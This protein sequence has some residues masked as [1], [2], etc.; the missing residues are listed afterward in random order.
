MIRDAMLAARALR[1]KPF[2]ALVGILTLAF[3]LGATTAVFAVLQAVLLRPLPYADPDRLVVLLHDGQSPVSPADYLDYR[4]QTRSFS[5]MAAAQV[6]TVTLT[7][8]GDPVRT[9]AL[10]V[11]S[12][13]FDTLGVPAALGRTFSRDDGAPGRDRV[14]VLSDR[15]WRGRFRADPHAIGRSITLDGDPYTVI[16]VMPPSFQFAPFWAT[17]AQLWR[18]LDLS[19]RLTDRGGRSLRVFARLR[20]GTSLQNAQADASAVAARLSAAYPD[21]NAKLGISVVPLQ[22]RV[23]ANTR[24]TLQSIAVMVAL[25]LLIACV[26][27][28]TLLLVW[29]ASR[30]RELAVRA[31]LGASRLRLIRER[32]AEAAILSVAGGLIGVACA[33]IAVNLLVASLPPASLPRQQDIG[34]DPLV[35]AAAAA[36]SIVCAA[37]AGVVP[38][39]QLSRRAGRD[40]LREGGRTM[41]DHAGGARL[42]R[43]LLAVEVALA[44]ALLCGA[45]LVGRSLLALQAV[46]PGFDPRGVLTFTL[47][48]KGLPQGEPSARAPYFDAVAR[49]LSEVP[50]VR[51]VGAINHLPLAGDQ[52]RLT[53][54]IA[55]RAAPPP[56][57]RQGA[58]WRVVR[59]GYF[60]TMRLPVRGRTFTDGDRQNGLPVIIVNDAMARRHWPGRDPLGAQVRIGTEDDSQ[61]M[62]VVGVAADARQQDWTGAILEE[63]YVPYAQHA[64][65][66]GGAELSFVVRTAGD[67][68]SYV[69]RVQQAVWSVDPNVPVSGVQTMER[70]VSDQLWRARVTAALLGTF[71]IVALSL[72]AV[73]ILS[74]TSYVMSRRTREIGIRIALGASR[75]DVMRLAA[76]DTMLPIAG[77]VAAGAAASA[78]LSGLVR[79]L[80]YDVSP[81]DP[82]T[83]VS[84]TA[85]LLVVGMLAA[86]LPARR[87]SRI[88]PVRALREE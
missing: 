30:D 35:L 56:D 25:V 3:G 80:L 38:A 62:T 60:E 22:E 42:R 64:R 67:P 65:D 13:L 63:V 5:S 73:G 57:E 27:V 20:G 16:G 74:V 47:G 75:R 21:T 33:S 84:A 24:P 40:A 46:N 37:L 49:S 50:G 15:L 88:E 52:W 43:T 72:A 45:G 9:E 29:G 44:L 68:D 7:G 6:W 82:M 78:A 39:L 11:T 41:T 55:G 79:S 23:V 76:G 51:A 1:R 31:A 26:N 48:I 34:L 32:L 85:V 2:V 81:G 59:P 8:A 17:G 18:P 69:Q 61:W 87:A 70:I 71:A 66:F 19:G 83:F 12:N 28:A 53:F 14:V 36:L 4:D 77:G 54:L 10:Q 86:W 58:I